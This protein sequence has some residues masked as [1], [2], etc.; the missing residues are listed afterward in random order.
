MVGIPAMFLVFLAGISSKSANFIGTPSTNSNN[1]HRRTSNKLNLLH[2]SL[3]RKNSTANSSFV[4]MLDEE[5]ELDYELSQVG[6][7]N[8][9]T[10][11]A[12]NNNSHLTVQTIDTR[13]ESKN[14]FLSSTSDFFHKRSLSITK[15][16]RVGMEGR[17]NVEVNPYTGSSKAGNEFVDV[18]INKGCAWKPSSAW[19]RTEDRNSAAVE[20]IRSAV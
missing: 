19:S 14:S 11:S 12:L 17:R 15:S 16:N 6:V 1:H 18:E 5:E 3:G 20:E 13:P 9:T 7:V 4:G 10:A 8:T 2:L